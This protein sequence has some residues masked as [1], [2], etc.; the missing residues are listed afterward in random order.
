MAYAATL[1]RPH[2]HPSPSALSPPLQYNNSQIIPSANY[3]Y[4]VAGY[5]VTGPKDLHLK[6]GTYD[7][8]HEST[9]EA[10]FALISELEYEFPLHKQSVRSRV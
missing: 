7:V 4:N 10:H 8:L 6:P 3:T 1:P 2:P 5:L 9:E